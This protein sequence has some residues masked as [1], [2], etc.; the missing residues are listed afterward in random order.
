MVG[1]LT[2]M[3]QGT[4]PNLRER[5]ADIGQWNVADMT[6]LMTQVE[7]LCPCGCLNPHCIEL[8]SRRARVA[9]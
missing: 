6:I 1:T 7:L 4:G 2:T 9:D 3:R 5:S 8:M